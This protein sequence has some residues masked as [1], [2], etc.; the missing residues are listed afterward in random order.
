MIYLKALVIYGLIIGLLIWGMTNAY[1]T[2][3]NN[4]QN[5]L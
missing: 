4:V 3:D 1:P 5:V 2:I